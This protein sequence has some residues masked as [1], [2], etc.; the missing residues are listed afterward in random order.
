MSV[1]LDTAKL[2][3]IMRDLGVN[4]EEGI[5]VTAFEAEGQIK[6]QINIMDIID[7]GAFLNSVHTERKD[8][9]LY[10]VADGVDYGVYQEL[11]HHNVAARPAFAQG[12]ENTGNVL[13]KNFE[14]LFK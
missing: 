5:K 8:A 4:T 2:D 9:K 13:A 11:G 6:Q 1:R 14:R 7:T 3:Q 10:W 12:I